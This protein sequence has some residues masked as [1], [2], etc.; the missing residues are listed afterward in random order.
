MFGFKDISIDFLTG[1]PVVV[2]FVLGLLL[3]L[4]IYLYRRTNPPLPLYIRIILGGLRLIAILALML[5]LANPKSFLESRTI[6][7]TKS[8]ATA[9]AWKRWRAA[10]A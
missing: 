4:A 2:W 10:S 5:T 1:S 7:K 3:L 8:G 9:E 6:M